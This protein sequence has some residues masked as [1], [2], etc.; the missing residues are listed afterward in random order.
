MLPKPNPKGVRQWSTQTRGRAVEPEVRCSEYRA[1]REQGT[2][3]VDPTA[4]VYH[5][6]PLFP[7]QGPS[8]FQVQHPEHTLDKPIIIQ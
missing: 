8:L 2:P 4:G 6:T 7:V 1:H 3:G 5:V